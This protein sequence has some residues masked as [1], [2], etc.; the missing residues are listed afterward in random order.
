MIGW[1]ESERRELASIRRRART[2]R[3]LRAIVTGLS[4]ALAVRA[5]IPHAVAAWLAAM[6]L[7]QALEPEIPPALLSRAQELDRLRAQNPRAR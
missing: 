5:G 2:V 3:A 7:V 1:T 4:I 6:L